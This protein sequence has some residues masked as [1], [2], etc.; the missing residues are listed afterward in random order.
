[1]DVNAKGHGTSK[2]AGGNPIPTGY[3]A[4]SN[5]AKG[6][7]FLARRVI[8]ITRIAVDAS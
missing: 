6:K 1:M 4:Q 2:D 3:L 7:P 5:G 8:T